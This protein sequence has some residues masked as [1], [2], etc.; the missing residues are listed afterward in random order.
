MLTTTIEQKGYHLT[1]QSDDLNNLIHLCVPLETDPTTGKVITAR[2]TPRVAAYYN[3]S[4]TQPFGDWLKSHGFSPYHYS[5]RRQE[6]T[7]AE[8]LAELD[9]ILAKHGIGPDQSTQL[10]AR[11]SHGD[12]KAKS[13][14]VTL[15]Q[16]VIR[17]LED[18]GYGKNDF[19]R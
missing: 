17:D 16:P 4:Y 7:V 13:D 2:L 10:S 9:Q 8:A 19:C 12:P 1:D 15:L 11:V 3:G 5:V 6:K 18:L 14:V